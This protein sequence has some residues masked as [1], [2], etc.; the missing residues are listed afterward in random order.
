[1]RLHY[2]IIKRLT[3]IF[4]LFMLTSFFCMN[5]QESLELPHRHEMMLNLGSTVILSFPELS[6][7]YIL[8]KDITIG[9]AMRLS[10][11][12]EDGSGFNAKPFARWF[13]SR[14]DRQPATGFF[15]EA[16]SALGSQYVYD[17]N[18]S[19]KESMFAAG[20]GLGV[21]YKSLWKNNWTSE[22]F[23]GFGRNFIYDKEVENED[24]SNYIRIGISIGKRF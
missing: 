12:K 7:E 20:L 23:F 21:G 2:L 1:M 5:A 6:Y 22:L 9:A 18:T 8:N 19:E 13:L 3:T 15:L 24:V 10:F 17:I 11:D 4:S 14:K 16:H